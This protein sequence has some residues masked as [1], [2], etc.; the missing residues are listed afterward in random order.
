MF[1]AQVAGKPRHAK[2]EFRAMT[3]DSQVSQGLGFRALGL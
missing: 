2:V 1:R 3:H